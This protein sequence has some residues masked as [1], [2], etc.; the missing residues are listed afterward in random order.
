MTRSPV[1]ET[2]TTTASAHSSLPPYPP[3][4]ID[5]LNRWAG[6]F[7]P[8]PWVFYALFAAGLVLIQLLA[9]WLEGSLDAVELLPVIVFNSAFTPFLL[10]LIALLDRQALAVLRTMRPVL[11]TSASE[12]DRIAYQLTHMP[13][14]RPL[15]AGLA[16][17]VLVILMELLWRMPLRYAP[18]ANLAVFNVVFQITDKSS[19]F[20]FG[21]F[22]YHTLRQLR[23][24]NAV[25]ARHL[26]INLFHLAPVRGFSR[27]TAATAIGLL[28]G[29]YAWMLINPELLLDPVILGVVALITVLAVLVFVWPL[30]G[31]HRRLASE[32]EGALQAV[33][34][35][36]ESALALFNTGFDQQDFAA[37]ERL[38]ATIASLEILHRRVKAIP[39]WPWEPETARFVLTTIAFPLFLAV[40]RFVIDLAMN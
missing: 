2:A 36:F 28:V 21:V 18:L 6:Q 4:W 26:R 39:T 16:V 12:Y 5:R 27:L 22:I 11:D 38:N 31:L 1:T 17:L 14:F 3:S 25:H 19:A 13:V 30:Y 7:G 34:Q 15:L 10:G 37:L 9:L 24:V 33:D 20:L 8:R 35:R 40:I 23:Q 29:V 32:K